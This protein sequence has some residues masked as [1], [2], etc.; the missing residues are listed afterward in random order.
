VVVI[1]LAVG[2]QSSPA[3]PVV[4]NGSLH[5]ANLLLVTIDTLRQDRVG[6]FGNQTGLTPTIDRLA[7]NGVRFTHAFSTASLTLPAHAS[8]FT[9]LLPR[10]HGIHSNT[11][12]R[13]AAPPIQ[14]PVAATA[15]NAEILGMQDRIGLSCSRTNCRPRRVKDA[16][17]W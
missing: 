4:D 17:R 15:L 10:H 3:R 14:A 16:G 8:I 13:L 2:C 5:G 6:A 7:A 1:G 11:R 12:F 9:G